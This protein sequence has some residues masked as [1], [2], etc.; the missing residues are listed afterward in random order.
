MQYIQDVMELSKESIN[1]DYFTNAEQSFLSTDYLVVHPVIGPLEFGFQVIFEWSLTVKNKSTGD[2]ILGVNGSQNVYLLQEK[3]DDQH[4]IRE[5][6]IQS[7][8]DFLTK[9]YAWLL[10][11]PLKDMIFGTVDY[12][13]V[14]SGINKYLRGRK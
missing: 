2:F 9:V 6:V 8:E 5:F 12:E 10:N 11:T 7:H 3:A 1:G 4:T 14:V 13:T